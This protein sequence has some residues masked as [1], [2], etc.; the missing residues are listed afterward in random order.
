[1]K[2][3]HRAGFLCTAALFTLSPSLMAWQITVSDSGTGTIAAFFGSGVCNSIGPLAANTQC[4][5]DSF[6]TQT[7]SDGAYSIVGS[8]DAVNTS[9]QFFLI[10]LQNFIITRNTNVASTVTVT[11]QQTFANAVTSEN[12]FDSLTGT[13]AGLGNPSGTHSLN[14]SS[15]ETVGG[16]QV[17][18]S[19][20]GTCAAPGPSTIT[21]G[22]LS[23][24]GVNI[25]TGNPVN[26]T[27][28]ITVNFNSA[29][30]GGTATLTKFALSTVPE[31][32]SM[33]LIGSGLLGLAMFRRKIFRG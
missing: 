18:S 1:M 7:T 2:T 23:S 5:A 6:T 16:A 15:T 31:P 13:C 33:M 4:L 10:D 27:E 17:G 21:A 12:A 19:L 30:N 9:G 20:N 14:I 28:S 26:L 11:L 25:P 22:L 3:I 29:S 24:S 32:V 8:V